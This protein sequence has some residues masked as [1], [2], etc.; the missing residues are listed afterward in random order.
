MAVALQEVGKVAGGPELCIM[1]E[2]RGGFVV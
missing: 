2:L 1:L